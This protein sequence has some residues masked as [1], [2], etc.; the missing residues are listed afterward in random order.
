LT[1][2]VVV[3]SLLLPRIK[4]ATLLRR[5][6]RRSRRSALSSPFLLALSLLRFNFTLALAYLV[7]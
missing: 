5:R 3:A 6:L 1:F 4:D 2:V 7:K